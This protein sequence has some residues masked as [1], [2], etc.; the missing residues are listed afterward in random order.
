MR[1]WVCGGTRE[2]RDNST[3]T[4]RNTHDNKAGRD[5]LLNLWWDMSGKCQEFRDVLLSLEVRFELCSAGARGQG[6]QELPDAV[7]SLRCVQGKQKL[8]DAVLNLVVEGN[9]EN[10][11]KRCE[12]CAFCLRL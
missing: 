3:V 8:P 2:T 4:Q 12:K 7:L 1:F 5:V 10:T 11:I 6:K 9:A